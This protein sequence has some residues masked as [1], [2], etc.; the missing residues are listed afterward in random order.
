[1]RAPDERE[2]V[3]ERVPDARARAFEQR[4]EKAPRRANLRRERRRTIRGVARVHPRGDG[5]AGEVEINQF[6]DRVCLTPESKRLIERSRALILW[7]PSQIEQRLSRRLFAR[8]QQ[9]TP[10]H[11]R[12]PWLQSSGSRQFRQPSGREITHDP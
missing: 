12:Q 5:S 6:R 10:R 9:Q 4:E 8:P 2:Q 3:V 1:M 7:Q 11:A